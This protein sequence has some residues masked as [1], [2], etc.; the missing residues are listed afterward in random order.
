MS[1]AFDALR[2]TLLRHGARPALRGEGEEIS[3]ARLLE[4]IAERRGVLEAVGARRV[5]LALDNGPQWALWD[6]A[7]LAGGQV[8]VPLPGFFSPTQQMHVLD[9][10]GIDTLIV[11]PAAASATPFAGFVPVAPGILQRTPPQLPA[12][13]AGTAKI[14][15]TSGSTG[16][17]K[18]VCLSAAAQ[19]AVAHSVAQIGEG[20]AVERH[21]GVLPLATLLENIAGLYAGLLAG[22]CVELLAMRTIGFS[23]GGGFDPARF[24]QTLLAH[25]PQSLILLP[26]MLL[27]LVGA[28]ELG[29]ALPAGLRFVAVGGGQVSPR[30]LQRAEALGLPVYEGYGLSECASVVCLNTPSARRLG[31]VGRPLPHAA[32]RIGEDGEVQVRGARMLGYLGEAPLADELATDGVVADGWLGTGDLGHLDDGFLVLHGRKKHQFV[33]AYGRNV[34]PEWVEAELVQQG[35]IAQAWVHGEALAENFAVIVPRRADCSDAE[36]EAAVAAANA[37]LPDYA[38]AHR[39][40]R[41][42][43]PFTPGNGFLTANGRLRRAALAAHYLPRIGADGGAPGAHFTAF[44]DEINHSDESDT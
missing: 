35:P 29:R 15:Y 40:L 12:L 27:A 25:R 7:L 14:T 19:L 26:Q 13:P 24:L 6:L 31:T 32:V 30:L 22:A 42:E 3:Y 28:A 4:A 11:D 18:G 5:A 8:C 38:R 9:S 23:G 36:L 33:T 39:W 21:L 41:A 16:Q 34:N 2:S 43:A 37:G 17:P 10:A 1:D 20:G 44:S